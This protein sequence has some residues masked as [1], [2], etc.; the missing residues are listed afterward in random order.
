MAEQGLSSI[1]LRRNVRR[2]IPV[3]S[4]WRYTMSTVNNFGRKKASLLEH[5]Q[6]LLGL[7][8]HFAIKVSLSIMLNPC[9][10]LSTDSSFVLIYNHAGNMFAVWRKLNAYICY[11]TQIYSNVTFANDEVRGNITK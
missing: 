3:G 6:H 11:P 10:R 8:Y 1:T 5:S 7:Q 9:A 2:R 4:W